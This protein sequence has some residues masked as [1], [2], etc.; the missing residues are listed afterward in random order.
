MLIGK[1][2]SDTGANV[3]TLYLD[4]QKKFLRTRH[5]SLRTGGGNHGNVWNHFQGEYLDKVFRASGLGRAVSGTVFRLSQ[6]GSRVCCP[7][8]WRPDSTLS[9]W[10]KTPP[11]SYGDDFALVQ[12]VK[13]KCSGEHEDLQY[14]SRRPFRQAVCIRAQFPPG[15]CWVDQKWSWSCW[16]DRKWSWERKSRLSWM[17]ELPKM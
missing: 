16:V 11:H 8:E 15:S 4:C 17:L 7:C 6:A 9:C 2:F 10:K 3:Y 14:G 12:D 1:K 13:V 5:H